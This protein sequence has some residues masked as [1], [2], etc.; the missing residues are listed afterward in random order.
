M[1]LVHAV[2]SSGLSVAKQSVVSVV[3]M[4]KVYFSWASS[5]RLVSSPPNSSIGMDLTSATGEE[6]GEDSLYITNSKRPAEDVLKIM[7]LLFHCKPKISQNSNAVH[8]GCTNCSHTMDEKCMISSQGGRHSSLVS[9][10]RISL[11]L[12][13][14]TVTPHNFKVNN[15]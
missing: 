13:P 4:A 11:W 1:V 12:M 7:C 8:G 2:Y 3:M 10:P 15:L 14:P 9:T 5:L 6:P